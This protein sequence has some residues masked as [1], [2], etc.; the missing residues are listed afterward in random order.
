MELTRSCQ[1]LESTKFVYDCMG[2]IYTERS[3]YAR[4]VKAGRTFVRT[5]RA[6]RRE[7]RQLRPYYARELCGLT[8]LGFRMVPH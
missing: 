7:G 8:Y 3:K 5:T 4:E 6:E 2:I 1:I